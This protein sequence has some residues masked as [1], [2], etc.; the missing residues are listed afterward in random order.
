[1][2]AAVVAL[3]LLA[4]PA[5]G[6]DKEKIAIVDLDAPSGMLGLSTQVI[7]SIVNE[8]M[9]TKRNVIG[10]DDLREKLGNKQMN[11]VAKCADKP[12]CAAEKLSVIGATKAV[13]GRLNRDDKNYLLQLWF[14]DLTNLSVISEVDR[15]ILIAS[16]RFQKDVDAAVPGFLRGEREAHGTLII[17]ATTTNAQVTINGE[18]I[19]VAPLTTSLKPGK[20][21]VRVEKPKYLPVKRLVSVEANQKS[22]EEFRML[23][24]P[25]EKEEEELP[26]LASKTPEG[27][28][29]KSGGFSPSAATIIF[30]VATLASFG[31]G[32]GFGVTSKGQYDGLLKGYDPA[33]DTYSGTR[34]TALAAQRN[35]TGANVSFGVAGAALI[36]TVVSVVLDVRSPKEQTDVEVTP[37]ATPGGGGLIIGGRF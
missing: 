26:A 15:S 2:K 23:L 25:G 32:L 10:P 29:A 9:K 21:E 22:V 8:A 13:L 24:Q 4:A 1:M 37:A 30:G 3:A 34:A 20:Y 18:F 5:L 28:A 31:I 14:V 35:A 11:E 27:E 7:K 19:G 17:N 36:A 6:A 33:T 16:R 12:A